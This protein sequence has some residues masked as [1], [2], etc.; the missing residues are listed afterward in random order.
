MKAIHFLA[1]LV[2]ISTLGLK[3]QDCKVYIPGTIGTQTELT[4]YDKKDKPTG[5]SKQTLLGIKQSGDTTVYTLHQVSTDSKG[6]NP[7][8]ANYN[9]KCFNGIFYFDMNSFMDQKTMEAYKDMQIKISTDNTLIPS[10]MQAGQQLKDGFIK[11]EILAGPMPITMKVDVVNRK[12]EGFEKVTTSAGT[13]DCV[14]ISED[15]LGNWGFVKTTTH[16]I[17]WY[18]AEIGAVRSETYNKGKLENYTVLTNVK[19]K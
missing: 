17:T 5:I 15:I 14:K 13:F 10:E 16:N 8:E 11:M 7:V 19:K 9:F 6:Q 4:S 1:P 3:A 12:V 2:F 18:S